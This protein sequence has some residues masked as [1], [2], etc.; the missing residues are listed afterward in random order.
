[1]GLHHQILQE[2]ENIFIQEVGTILE[3]DPKANETGI[4]SQFTDEIVQYEI[5]D[6]TK[7]AIGGKLLDFLNRNE[8][9]SFDYC[10]KISQ[11][12]YM[13]IQQKIDSPSDSDT[14]EDLLQQTEIVQI[15]YQKAAK[16]PAKWIVDDELKQQ[17]KHDQKRLETWHG[18]KKEALENAVQIAEKD[19]KLKKERGEYIKL[20]KQKKSNFWRR[21]IKQ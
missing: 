5:K 18:Y 8:D 1:M 4:L 13:P 15:E 7:K 2:K 9:N 17:I 12:I 3:G 21:W 19:A 6:D 11:Q 20:Q 14:F 10:K 16:G